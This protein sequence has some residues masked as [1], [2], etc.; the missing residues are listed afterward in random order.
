[1]NKNIFLLFFFFFFSLFSEESYQ[2]FSP[3]AIFSNDRLILKEKIELQHKLG[4][5]SAQSAEFEHFQL[6]KNNPFSNVLLQGDV[7]V[8]FISGGEIKSP[9]A[10]IDYLNNQIM[11]SSDSLEKTVCYTDIFQSKEGKDLSLKISSRQADVCIMDKKT[12]EKQKSIH[13]ISILTFEKNVHI[14]FSD[15]YTFW[16]GKALYLSKEKKETKKWGELS[17]FPEKNVNFCHFS[18]G[19]NTI[20]ASSIQVNIENKEIIFN[21]AK[22]NIS[23]FL[24]EQKNISFSSDN[25]FWDHFSRRLV[26]KGNVSLKEKDYCFLTA[27][28]VE[29]YQQKGSSELAI[30]KIKTFGETE[31]FFIKEGEIISSL[32]C[33]GSIELDN[34][35]KT[36]IAHAKKKRSP[37]AEKIL[38]RD[39]DII[40]YADT[41]KVSYR[42]EEEFFRIDE[43][44]LQGEVLFIS[45]KIKDTLSFGIAD[46]LT[47]L[48]TNKN[49]MLESL[50]QKKVLF[51]KD[52]DSLRLS[53]NAIHV[54]CDDLT[55]KEAIKG[56]GSV[57]FSFNLEEEEFF[58]KIFSQYLGEK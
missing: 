15:E 36:F 16:G 27:K 56:I 4:Q 12:L 39:K 7:R 18:S 53:A 51:W 14:V 28:K 55:K 30:Q 31:F 6:N 34:N 52:D 38:F 3:K 24:G 35:N 57:R 19:D 48:P 43:I 58:H 2:I 29:L 11:F 46:K 25:M 33:Y 49:L 13:N 44:I 47:Y 1:M 26:M 54:H 23:S 50:P 9:R 5:I 40:L 10:Y 42:Q 41:A 45:Q 37:L 20:L 32:Q 17:L 21:K 22:G 8:L